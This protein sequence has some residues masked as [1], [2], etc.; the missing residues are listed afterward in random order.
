MMAKVSPAKVAYAVTN[1]AVSLVVMV[2]VFVVLMDISS[3]VLE[4]LR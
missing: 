3:K 2:V 1:G 4:R